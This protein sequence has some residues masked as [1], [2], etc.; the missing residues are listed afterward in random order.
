MKKKCA[1][2]GAFA[3]PVG[4]TCGAFEQLFGTGD[5]NLTA[6]K[7][8]PRGEGGML[9][10]PAYAIDE[11]VNRSKSMPMDIKSITINQLILEIDEQSTK[12]DSVTFKQNNSQIS[13]ANRWKS[14]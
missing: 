8:M 6:K 7:R 14:M 11:I 9:R 5:R 2:G 1:R 4:L 12:E 13:I 10:S 3:H